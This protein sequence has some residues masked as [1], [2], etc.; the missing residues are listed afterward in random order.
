[1]STIVYQQQGNLQSCFEP[2]IFEITATL[3]LKVPPS[4]PPCQGGWSIL[5]SLSGIISKDAA[6]WEKEAAYVHPLARRSASSS[7]RLSEKS[8]ALCTEALGSE[9]GTDMIESSSIFSSAAL[10]ASPAPTSRLASPEPTS[11]Q[12]ESLTSSQQIESR[13]VTSSAGAYRSMNHNSNRNSRNN[14][15]FPPPLTTI[16]GGAN[17]LRVKPHREGGRLII[18][19]VETPS[20]RTYLQAE[21]SNGRLRLSF[22]NADQSVDYPQITTT[23]ENDVDVDGEEFKEES[24]EIESDIN[25]ED[26]VSEVQELEEDEEKE[27]EGEEEESDVYM[28]RDMDGNTSNVE[29]E[30]GIKKCL[31]SRCKE[32]GHSQWGEPKTLWV[33]T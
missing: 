2:Q 4:S 6:A 31:L 3:K 25:G 30:M 10:I 9:T 29:V 15:N 27:E 33:S 32:S 13:N 8:L 12:E 28:A 18:R 1:M 24:D 20:K 17:S 23:E 16:S 21:R 19:A 14:N 22:F 5:Q 7:A 26:E 11:R